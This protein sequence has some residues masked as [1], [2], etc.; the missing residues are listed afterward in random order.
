M[1]DRRGIRAIVHG[2]VQGIGFRYKTRQAAAELNLTGWVRNLP[3]RTVE[4]EATG[5][6]AAIG[7]FIA[8]L[9]KGPRG[10]IVTQLDVAE[11]FADTV[12]EG[13]QI[14]Y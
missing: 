8:F 12:H 1:L 10:A 13:F 7:E 14:R 11:T 6:E 3:D 4:V 9:E 2:H 5:T